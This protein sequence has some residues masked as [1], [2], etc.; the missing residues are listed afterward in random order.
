MEA[1]EGG[2]RLSAV[3]VLICSAA[4]I[5]LAAVEKVLR[6][7]GVEPLWRRAADRRELEAAF[8]VTWPEVVLAGHP[9]S[10]LG[11]LQVLDFIRR[12]EAAI[13]LV[14][15]AATWSE[16]LALDCLRAGAIDCV[17][18]D[19]PLSVALGLLWAFRVSSSGSELG[20][21]R[22]ELEPAE[23]RCREILEQALDAAALV[24]SAGVVQY[25]SRASET[26][27]GYQPEELM[28]RPVFSVIHPDDVPLARRALEDCVSHGDRTVRL[29]F[30]ARHRDGSW[31]A[32]EAVV[33][34]RLSHP[35]I[36]AVVVNYRDVTEGKRAEAIL[37]TR[38]ERLS[39]AA[40]GAND[41]LWDWDLVRN[42]VYYSPRWKEMLGYGGEE[43]GDSPEEWFSRVH[44]DDLPH[45]KALLAAHLDGRTA[46]LE[47]EYR[48]RHE[49][50]EY[51]W[52]LCRGLAARD[53]TGR[54]L[55]PGP[56]RS[57]DTS[58][59]LA[60]AWGLRWRK[61]STPMRAKCYMPRI[62]RC[63]G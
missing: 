14:V 4:P 17:A 34:N 15:L 3:R 58:L 25:I 7:S 2:Y 11:A 16:Q 23:S 46:R 63:I 26:V 49:S 36:A 19:S 38:V 10:E 21:A 24:D 44:P 55:C 61:D 33:V 52:I 42:A 48:L 31:R 47:V 27:L 53:C 28:G 62:E 43:M 45:L 30:R 50:G 32:I 29:E 22:R 35:G 57:G 5:D 37:V 1:Q 13:P 54:T 39:L 51:R 59:G 6:E 60:R 20:R 41:G 56:G 12:Q 8:S 18:A 40:R 9:G